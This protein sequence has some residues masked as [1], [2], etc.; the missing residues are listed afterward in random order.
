MIG[1]SGFISQFENAVRKKMHLSLDLLIS[2][3][4][5]QMVGY[6]DD[7]PDTHH[8]IFSSLSRVLN[9]L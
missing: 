2:A 6:S 4:I 5:T 7:P 1:S 9:L 3:D 8:S